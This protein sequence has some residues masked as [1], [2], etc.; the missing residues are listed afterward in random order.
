MKGW[1]AWAA[2]GVVAAAGASG[3]GGGQDPPPTACSDGARTVLG[4]L[5]RAPGDVS[6]EGGTLIS[7]CV[8]RSLDTGQIQ[9]LGFTY[10]AAA[11]NELQLM[12]HSDAAAL[13]LGF[14][15][16][17]VRRGANK[18]NGVQLELVRRLDQVAGVGGP[19]G[20]RRAAYRRGM[21][22]GEDHG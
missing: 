5:Q 14:L 13:Q 8:R 16:G 4:A 18:T 11:N 6:L 17:A 10:L 1:L 21:A 7:T 15:V 2:A 22:A 20:P 9:T 12:P 3:C 19:P